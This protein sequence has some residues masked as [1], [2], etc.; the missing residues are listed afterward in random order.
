MALPGSFYLYQGDE[1]GLPEVED[2]PV[3]RIQDP[4]HFQ[5]GGVD[6]GRDGCRVPLPWS[7]TRPPFGFSP[8]GSLADTW[9]PQPAD[10]AELTA[11]AQHG[12]RGSTLEL[13]RQALRLRQ[14]HLA[15]APADLHWL[16]A[17]AD[18]LA[19]RRGDV[20]CVVNLR[21]EAVR[22]PWS[23]RLLVASAD[24]IDGCLPAHAAAWI[25]GPNEDS[26]TDIPNK[27]HQR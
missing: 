25:H 21:A 11:A 24:P 18:V 7:G 3:E 17:P 8:G 5:S 23:G 22:L 2:L 9:L 20:V 13:F 15:E 6:P 12:Q 1:L 14:I 16:A 19:F 4:M 27:E 10:W 26:P